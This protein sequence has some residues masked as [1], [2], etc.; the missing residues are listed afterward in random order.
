MSLKIRLQRK[1]RK[2][3]PFYQIVAADARAPRDGKFIQ[4]LGIYNPLTVPA[5][6][7]LDSN[8][9]YDWLMKG[10]Q[11]TDT[12]R[13]ILKLKGVYY[14]K[15]LQR[16]VLKGAFDQEAADKM[17]AE[18]LDAKSAKIEKRKEATKNA[19]EER[20]AKIFGVAPV[21]EVKV[22][23]VVEETVV[24]ETATEET[25]AEE[26]VAEETKPEETVAETTEKTEEKDA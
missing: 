15:H 16:G 20:R 9:A 18:W 2:K 19:L 21:V 22:E 11:P 10:A 25:V 17:L 24:E 8:A 6:I 4:K 14:K 1:G 7:D 26:T 3:K 23:E 13:A 5:T 12:V